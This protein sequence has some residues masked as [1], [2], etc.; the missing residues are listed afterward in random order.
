MDLM[1]VIISKFGNIAYTLKS[2]STVCM[3][4]CKVSQRVTLANQQGTEDTAR[5]EVL[6]GEAETRLNRRTELN[7]A[8]LKVLI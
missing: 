1:Y 8:E 7:P 2:M 3:R 6:S 4:W 5:A